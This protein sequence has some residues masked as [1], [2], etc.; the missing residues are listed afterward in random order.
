MVQITGLPK[1]GEY[2]TAECDICDTGK[3]ENEAHF[4]HCKQCEFDMCVECAQKSKSAS[5]ASETQE[6]RARKSEPASSASKS[7]EVR[8]VGVYKPSSRRSHQRRW[9]VKRQVDGVTKYG[10]YYET[11]LEAAKAS[12]AVVRKYEEFQLQLNFPT[13]EEIKKRRK[14]LLEKESKVCQQHGIIGV[15]RHAGLKFKAK[16]VVGEKTIYGEVRDNIEEAAKDADDIYRK[17]VKGLVD[18]CKINFRR[19]GEIGE[20]QNG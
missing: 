19:K 14:I 18:L 13:E 5:S 11:A 20:A 1:G 6:I 12:D 17:H 2:T 16:R 10:G 3:L 9:I 7:Q 8:Y 4:Y 15:V